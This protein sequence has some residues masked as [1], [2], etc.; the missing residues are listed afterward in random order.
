MRS[1]EGAEGHIIEWLGVAIILLT[2][3][4]LLVS[5]SPPD[6]GTPGIM[7]AEFDKTEQEMR[8]TVTVYPTA[9]AL[10]AS[11]ALVTQVHGPDR[12]GE[13]VNGFSLWTADGDWCDIHVLKVPS[14][15]SHARMEVL[16]HELAHC[17]YGKY[18]R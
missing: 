9:E 10:A 15:A 14:A 3:L 5:C 4:V 7:G 2:G 8:V 18:H 1:G 16:G 6:P 12:S 17:L 13:S 11:H